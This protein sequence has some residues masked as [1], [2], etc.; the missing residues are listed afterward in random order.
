MSDSIRDRQLGDE[1]QRLTAAHY[2][3]AFEICALLERFGRSTSLRR[4]SLTRPKL[5]IIQR[6][7]G[8]GGPNREAVD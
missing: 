8:Y 2:R 4:V 5:T 6:R 1:P 7:R 3:D